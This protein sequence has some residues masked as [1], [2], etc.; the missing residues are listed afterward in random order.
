[1]G[2]GLRHPFRSG[3]VGNPVTRG[4]ACSTLLR[5]LEPGAARRACLRAA[6]SSGALVHVAA[7]TLGLGSS[8][9]SAIAF[10]TAKFLG[11]GHRPRD[12][13]AA[14][15]SPGRESREHSS[16]LAL[17]A[18]SSMASSSACSIRRSRCSSSPSCRSF[19]AESRPRRPAG[20]VARPDLDGLALVT[21]D[22]THCGGRARHWMR[23]RMVLGRRLRRDRALYLGLG[24]ST[25]SAEPVS[26]ITLLFLACASLSVSTAAA[27]AIRV[28]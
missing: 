20:D 9:T 14:L 27:A 1:M 17:P 12:S 28:L 11:A 10:R 4:P 26:A 6:S 25:A 7:A 8:A 18:L 13:H 19:P 22:P 24:V 15:P 3:G 16:S 21:D 5:E 2:R 23:G